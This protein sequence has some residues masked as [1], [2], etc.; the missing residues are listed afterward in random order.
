MEG[1]QFPVLPFQVDH[2][3]VLLN[4]TKEI[5]WSVRPT[6]TYIRIYEYIHNVYFYVVLVSTYIGLM[7]MILKGRRIQCHLRRVTGHQSRSSPPRSKLSYD[8][9]RG[10]GKLVVHRQSSI[11]LWQIGLLLPSHLIW[12]P[13]ISFWLSH[14]ISRRWHAVYR[15]GHSIP[16]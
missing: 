16:C 2:N 10:G 6:R 9:D 13:W 8:I 4:L 12:G 1:Q 7:V 11:T 5:G 14:Q 15:F 3:I